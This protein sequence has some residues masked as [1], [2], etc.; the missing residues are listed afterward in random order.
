MRKDHD[1]ATIT[2]RL[3]ES[4][5]NA[6]PGIQRRSETVKL[7]AMIVPAHMWPRVQVIDALFSCQAPPEILT[8]MTFDRTLLNACL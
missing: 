4:E 2:V 3:V 5:R 6:C 7:L 8:V 1:P